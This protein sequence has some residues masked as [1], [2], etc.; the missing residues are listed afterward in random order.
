MLYHT[1]NCCNSEEQK[2]QRSFNGTINSVGSQQSTVISRQ[3]AV[4]SQQSAVSS[5]QS[6]VISRQLSVDS[7]QSSV[8]SQQSTVNSHDARTDCLMKWKNSLKQTLH[9]NF[10]TS[11]PLNSSTIQ[12]LNFHYPQLIHRNPQPIHRVFG[13]NRT[14]IA[15]SLTR[16]AIQTKMG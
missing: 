8:D 9:F 3:S 4:G 15:E 14:P 11:Q 13:I 12:P 7:Q 6:S 1:T 2:Y 5:R 10:S 16:T